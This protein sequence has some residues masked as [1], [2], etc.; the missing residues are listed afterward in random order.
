MAAQCARKLS[1]PFL[2]HPLRT[3]PT[4]TL[5]RP[6]YLSSKLS[7]ISS[8]IPPSDPRLISLH[9]AYH[10][11]AVRVPTMA[12]P[13]SYYMRELPKE[14]LIGYETVE[15]KRLF[16]QA[17]LEGGLEAFFPLSQQ[18]LTASLTEY[19]L[20]HNYLQVSKD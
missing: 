9:A 13:A 14:H 3:G 6:V 7:T 20:L 16:K 1:L 8:W 10:A 4:I 15:G 2:L 12:N 18:F 19:L 11:P 17:L 5:L